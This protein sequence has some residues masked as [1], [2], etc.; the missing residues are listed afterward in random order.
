MKSC[1]KIATHNSG[2]GESSNKFIDKLL[3]PFSR[4]QSKTIKEQYEL[5]V[6]L[7]DLRVNKR[8]KL[9]HGLWESSMCIDHVLDYLNSQD[10]DVYVLLTMEGNYDEVLHRKFCQLKDRYTNIK[11]VAFCHKKPQ[12]T[13]ISIF[14]HVDWIKDFS[15]NTWRKWIPIPWLWSKLMKHEES[16]D[17]FV[18]RDFV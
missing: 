2:T 15:S 3:V 7:F 16:E 14:N 17:V 6:R 4:C 12:W 18:M 10:D 13:T 9:A 5:G 8:N 11:Y 1:I